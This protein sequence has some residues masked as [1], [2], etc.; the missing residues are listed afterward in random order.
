M[1]LGDRVKKLPDLCAGVALDVKFGVKTGPQSTGA[2]HDHDRS[3]VHLPGDVQDDLLF[4]GLRFANQGGQ[5]DDVHR[6][7]VN[8]L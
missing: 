1:D 2:S 5:V 4:V 3:R 7:Q 6:A 8:F